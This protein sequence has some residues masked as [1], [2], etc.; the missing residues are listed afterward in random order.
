MNVN[1]DSGVKRFFTRVQSQ[2]GDWCFPAVHNIL[3]VV[4]LRPT[5]FFVVLLVQIF[6]KRECVIM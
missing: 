2:E 3:V 5:A 1:K 4:Y 6:K